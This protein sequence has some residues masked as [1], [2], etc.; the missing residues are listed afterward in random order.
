MT[1]TTLP[2]INATLN[3]TACALLV[4][5]YI[6]IRRKQYVAHAYM[7]S[8]AFVVSMAFL[9]CYL[10]HHAKYGERTIGLPHGLLRDF[11]LFIILLPHVLLAIIMV[12]MI[13]RTLFLAYRRNW[14]AHPRIA[15]P[16][17]WIWLYVSITGVVIYWMLYHLFPSAT[18]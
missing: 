14:L 8:S 16:T 10:I 15:R 18:G 7:M 9:T 5:G 11:Y 13:F 17:F 3:A 2:V 12:P 4:I 1:A 6:F